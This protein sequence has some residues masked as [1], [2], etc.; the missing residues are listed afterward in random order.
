[1]LTYVPNTELGASCKFSL[2]LITFYRWGNHSWGHFRNLAKCTQPVK[3]LSG[4]GLTP[5]S[6][7]LQCPGTSH[8]LPCLQRCCC[9]TLVLLRPPCLRIRTIK[10]S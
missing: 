3:W 6:A 9:I 8:T 5:Q 4:N 7:G 1:M 2:I 10:D